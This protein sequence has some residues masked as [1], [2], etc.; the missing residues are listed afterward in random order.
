MSRLP[1]EGI[2]VVDLT[3]V[4]AGPFAT[5]LLAGLGAEVIRVDSIHHRPDMG[6]SFALWPTQEMLDGHDGA[7]YPNGDPG[8]RP[9][10]RGAFFNRV[11]WNK[12]SCCIDLR[13]PRGKE[14]FKS[15]IRVSDV[16]IENN[17]ATAMDSL[18]LGPEAL[19]AANPRLICIN[20]P[21]YGRSGPY[22]NFVGWGDN[23][24]ALTGHN[25]V[26]GYQDEAHPVHNTGMFHMDSTGG[27][28]AAIVAIM[29]LIRR[30]RTGEGTAVD[31]GQIQSFMPQL[32]EIYMDYAW[33]GRIQRT[34]GNRHPVAVQGCYRCRG[35]DRWV[36]VTVSNDRHW[37]GLCRAMG[38]PDWGHDPRFADQAGRRKYHDEIDGYIEAWTSVRDNYEAFHILQ[39]H[40]VPAGPVLTEQDTFREPHLNARGFF[41]VIQQEE[42]GA[43][44]YPGFLWKMSETPLF[45]RLPPPL[46]G[47]HNDYVFRELLGL[48]QEEIGSLTEEQIIGGDRY[49]WA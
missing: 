25:W 40:G 41:E 49:T 2:R 8:K 15:L 36:N 44:R 29:G 11:G 47:E 17:S 3:V 19:M 43:Y 39:A 48:A 32:G 7:R 31:F 30:R 34:T 1:L 28:M 35:E 42:V 22:K 46:M 14:I 38:D 9:W 37:Q 21:S 5:W 24:E 18:G 26:R 13:H 33:N 45:C 6:R 23:A 20:M 12:K 4:F 10:N 16:F 27:A